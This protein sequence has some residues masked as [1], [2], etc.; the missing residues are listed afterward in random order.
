M[1]LID[2]LL[3]G[4]RERKRKEELR[5][6]EVRRSIENLRSLRQRAIESDR[7]LLEMDREILGTLKQMTATIEE[8]QQRER[9]ESE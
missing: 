6:E 3:K 9:Q 5:K 7:E 1:N 2:F 4:S 8:G